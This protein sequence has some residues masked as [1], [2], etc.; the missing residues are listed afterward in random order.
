[1]H[2]V[3]LILCAFIYALALT[4]VWRYGYKTPWNK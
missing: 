2:P 4:T 3:V 1:M